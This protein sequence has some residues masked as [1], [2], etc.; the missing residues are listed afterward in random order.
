MKRAM[1]TR[2][3]IFSFSILALLA[4]SVINLIAA[5]IATTNVSASVNYSPE[6][7]ANL[8]IATS[9]SN[10]SDCYY[11]GSG[12]FPTSITQIK[13][14][15]NAND[16]VSTLITGLKTD[17][18]G[19]LAIYIEVQNTS[20]F[21]IFASYSLA[22][23]SNVVA[24]YQESVSVSQGATAIGKVVLRV[25]N[26]SAVENPALTIS[27][28]RMDGNDES[29]AYLA[30]KL[31]K[32]EYSTDNTNWTTIIKKDALKIYFYAN[33][34]VDLE[35]YADDANSFT[36][37]SASTIYIKATNLGSTSLTLT[38][39]VTPSNKATIAA[40]ASSSITIS[41]AEKIFTLS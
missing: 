2:A 23:T 27:L 38:D 3:Y 34:L 35:V 18:F 15:Q 26:Q 10:K 28:Q 36:I 21:D 22:N 14:D 30:N 7:Y 8:R 24:E 31:Y 17:E 32:I 6:V 19:R 40:S 39:S 9:D 12:A 11:S 1:R 37:D 13:I 5:S 41:T 29:K 20:A 25:I 16:S 33:G 4:L